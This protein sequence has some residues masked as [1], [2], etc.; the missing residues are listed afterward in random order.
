MITLQLNTSHE[1]A[2]IIT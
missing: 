2:S 1:S